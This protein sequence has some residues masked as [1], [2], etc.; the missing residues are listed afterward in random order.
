MRHMQQKWDY[1]RQNREGLLAHHWA[2]SIDKC[3]KHLQTASYKWEKSPSVQD[4]IQM[5]HIHSAPF[6][7]WRT[8]VFPE[9]EW[10]KE[11][12]RSKQV[13]IPSIILGSKSMDDSDRIFSMSNQLLHWFTWR[14]HFNEHHNAGWNYWDHLRFLTLLFCLVTSYGTS[15]LL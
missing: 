13:N 12:S 10:V 6:V 15:C 2:S 11:S 9:N 1:V 3:M 4:E 7:L 8:E 5:G 14:A